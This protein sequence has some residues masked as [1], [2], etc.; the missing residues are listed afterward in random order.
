M[1]MSFGLV[2]RFNISSL[3][4]SNYG[5]DLISSATTPAT[6]EPIYHRAMAKQMSRIRVKLV[7]KKNP[8]NET[9]TLEIK[10][11][12]EKPYLTALKSNEMD[13]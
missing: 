3:N 7:T 8:F 4:F 10:G 2:P 11:M 6:L 1:S 12:D 9:G 13:P 5:P